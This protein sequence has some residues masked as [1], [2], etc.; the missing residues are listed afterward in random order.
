MLILV[1]TVGHCIGNNSVLELFWEAV[2]FVCLVARYWNGFCILGSRFLIAFSVSI[3]NSLI[4]CFDSFSIALLGPKVNVL[5]YSLVNF[6]LGR[7]ISLEWNVNPFLS[8]LCLF[9][10]A[11]VSNFLLSFLYWLS[12][13][14]LLVCQYNFGY[15]ATY[16]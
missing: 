11:S 10:F 16:R 4:Y 7:L 14:R 15:A 1:D 9:C 5:I 6:V 12:M 8:L 2:M 13:S 3:I